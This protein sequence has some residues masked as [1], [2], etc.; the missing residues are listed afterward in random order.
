[1]VFSSLLEWK[2]L[3]KMKMVFYLSLGIKVRD[4]LFYLPSESNARESLVFS[5][6]T[7]DFMRGGLVVS[8]EGAWTGAQYALRS[9]HGLGAHHG[10]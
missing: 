3:V 8:L 1:M 7:L 6:T 5:V 4:T 2:P 10:L 9:W